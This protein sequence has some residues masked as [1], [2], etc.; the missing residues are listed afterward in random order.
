MIDI[1]DLLVIFEW[2]QRHGGEFEF[3]IKKYI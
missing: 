1:N 3:M 2:I